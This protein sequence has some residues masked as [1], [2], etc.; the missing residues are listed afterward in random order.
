ML[1]AYSKPRLAFIEWH[2][3]AN[4]NIEVLNETINLYRY[5]DAT[6]QAEFLYEC[7]HETVTRLLPSEIRSLQQY[8]EMKAFISA[9]VDMPDRTAELLVLFLHQNDGMLSKR[10]RNKEFRNL[11]DEEIQV[12]ENR[13]KEIF[14]ES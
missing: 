8:D 1:E 11:S 10:A 13:F 14:T 5:F 4:G 6:P 7:V 3:T 12:F 2:P 9:C